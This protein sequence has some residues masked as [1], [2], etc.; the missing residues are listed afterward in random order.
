MIPRGA[1]VIF[2]VSTLA[3]LLVPLP[4]QCARILAIEPFPAKSHMVVFSA[5]TKELAR[6]GHEVVVVSAFPL[7][8]PMANYTDIDIMPY[9]D[10]VLEN[11]MGEKMY[12]MAEFTPWQM[13]FLMWNMGVHTTDS[14]LSSPKMKELLKDKR[15]FDLVLVEFFLNEPVYGFAHHFK[16]PLVLVCPFGGFHYINDINGNPAPLSYVPNPILPFSDSMSYSERVTNTFVTLLWNIGQYFYYLPRQDQIRRKIFG[17]DSPSVWELERSASLTLLNNHFSM[18]YPRPLVPSMVE[19]GGMHV[20]R[21]S[22]KLPADVQKFLDEAPEGAIYFS[23][24]SNLRSDQMPA[25]RRNAILA[26]F[27]ELPQRVLWKWESDTLPNQPPNVKLGKWLPQQDILAH[28]NVKLFITHGGL[29]SAQEAAFHGVPLV[30][31]PVFGDQMLNMRKAEL[32]GFGVMVELKNVSK[33]SLLWAINKVVHDP[34]YRREARRRAAV[35][36]DQPE[37][38]MDRAVFWTEY[39]LRHKGA[40]HLRTAAVDLPWYQLYLVDIAAPIVV[41][42]IIILFILRAV[43]RIILELMQKP[44]A[45]SKTNKKKQ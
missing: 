13:I 36:R 16:A 44:E 34:S 19:V 40:H 8:K 28:P 29:L 9:M 11:A 39:V 25:E 3:V 37:S 43:L 27:A 10:S 41:L 35:Y 17:D 38:P 45:T 14:V 6:R 15:G 24:G 5:L 22:G 33:S 23:M 12:D 7:S 42:L 20:M 30:G 18:S 4:T 1:T 26:A 31:I 2:V 32:G 21:T